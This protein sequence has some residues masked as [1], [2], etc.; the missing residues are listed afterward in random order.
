M[1]P[2]Q[3]TMSIILTIICMYLSE[4]IMIQL[5]KM[6]GYYPSY[7]QSTCYQSSFCMSYLEIVAMEEFS[8]A[9]TNDTQPSYSSSS[10][11][12]RISPN[13]SYLLLI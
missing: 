13:L 6:E 4:M 2:S 1:N 9:I 8:I 12:N 11:F 7:Y 5:K 3:Y 10:S